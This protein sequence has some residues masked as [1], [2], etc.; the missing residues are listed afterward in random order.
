VQ[1]EVF[2]LELGTLRTR[3]QIVQKVLFRIA[4]RSREDES[5]SL[6]LITP[7]PRRNVA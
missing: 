3:L 4:P 1:P 6:R 7:F 5:A 2:F